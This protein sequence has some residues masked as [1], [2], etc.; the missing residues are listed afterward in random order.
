VR[1]GDEEEGNERGEREGK[2]GVEYEDAHLSA[3][4]SSSLTAIT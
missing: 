1:R 2:K 3:T 4:F